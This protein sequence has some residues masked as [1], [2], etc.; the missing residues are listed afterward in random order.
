MT[1]DIEAILILVQKATQLLCFSEFFR[2]LSNCVS[3]RCQEQSFACQLVSQAPNS[4]PK[5][6]KL[7]FIEAG[8]H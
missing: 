2:R 7:L 5:T 1:V 6:Q 4:L 3:G 8:F